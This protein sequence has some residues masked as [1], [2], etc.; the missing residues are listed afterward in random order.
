L[1]K[2]VDKECALDKSTRDFG[3]HDETPEHCFE[4]KKTTD[5]ERI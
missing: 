3:H 4:A 5:G 2:W 1:L